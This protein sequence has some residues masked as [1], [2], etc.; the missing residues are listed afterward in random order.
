MLPNLARVAA[1]IGDPVRARMLFS[2]LDGGERSATELASSGN[3]SAQS[4]S[5]HLAKLVSGGLLR[6][7]SEGRRR[8]FRLASTDI[9]NAIEMLAS[10][11]P[12]A[13]VTS[14]SQH[15]SMERLRVARS[16]YDHLAGRL[17]V[18]V[19]EALS[20]LDV[21]RERDTSYDVTRSGVEFLGR[22]EID[23]EALQTLRRS[24]ARPC[25]DWTERRHHVA[26]VLGS[27]LLSVFLR[28]DWV[29]RHPQDRSLAITPDG[30]RHLQRL[31]A[32]PLP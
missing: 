19:T 20:R 18:G 32:L 3:A 25:L 31:F 15:T 23:V 17:G 1:L 2:L 8:Y 26:G 7:R 9:A 30:A 24:F 28:N 22:L 10:I 14:L 6:V 12:A 4:A 21:I 27:A 13:P 16:C 29:R 5:G 11:A